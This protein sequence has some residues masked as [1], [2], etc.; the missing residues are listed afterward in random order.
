VA[1]LTT[2]APN[3]PSLAGLF[4]SAFWRDRR[5]FVTGAT[6]LL[7]SWLTGALVAADADVVGLLRDDV[8]RS[9]LFRLKL[10][11]DITV[12]HGEL[13][14]LPLLERILA[15]YEVDTIFHLGAQT[16]VGVA[17]RSPVGTFEANVRGT[18][19]ILEA[20]RRSKLVR[21]VVVA[22]APYDVSKACADS[23]SRS[24]HATYGLPVV[25]T[26][27]GNLFGGGDLN[28]NRIVPGTMRAAIRGERP[29]I[30]SNGRFVRD[31]VYV[32]DAVHAYGVLAQRLEELELGGHAFNFS[33]DE[34]RTVLEICRAALDACGRS[35]LEP[36]VENGATD[37]LPYQS[38]SSA[39]AR[40]VLGWRPRFG[41]AEGLAA[42]AAWYRAHFEAR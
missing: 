27:M 28:W 8:P 2:L 18:Y 19:H 40:Q 20:A 32:L 4:D 37:E 33:T 14:N 12:V 16:I 3:P 38:L 7:G 1:R 6:G 31:Y 30:R 24:Y 10:L 11:R 23:L 22:L 25:V 13:E 39:K 17:T 21:R 29:V 36:I 9:N 5:V 34:P 15:E 41:E 42:T 26:R 35:D